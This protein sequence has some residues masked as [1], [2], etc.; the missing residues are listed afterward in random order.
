MRSKSVL[1]FFGD[2]V[3]DTD[4]QC[5]FS[6]ELGTTSAFRDAVKSAARRAGITIAIA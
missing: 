6:V 5:T 4:L 3:K 2:R 1:H